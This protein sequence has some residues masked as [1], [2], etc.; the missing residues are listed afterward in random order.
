[1]FC[2]NV[3]FQFHE[4]SGRHA[5]PYI[6]W[7]VLHCNMQHLYEWFLHCHGTYP[8][9]CMASQLHFLPAPSLFFFLHF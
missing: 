8:K 3:I 1:M 7:V 2:L 4:G 9:P 5:E 6:A